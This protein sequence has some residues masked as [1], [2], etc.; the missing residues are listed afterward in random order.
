MENALFLI[1]TIGRCIPFSW[2]AGFGNSTSVPSSRECKRRFYVD[3]K[4]ID[5]RNWYLRFAY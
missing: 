4:H 1:H 3:I 5:H 2:N